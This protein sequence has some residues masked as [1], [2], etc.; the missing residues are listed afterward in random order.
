M[1]LKLP[2]QG[3]V[4]QPII[5]QQTITT[6]RDDI[7]CQFVDCEK[8]QKLPMFKPLIMETT[9]LL[10]CDSYSLQHNRQEIFGTLGHFQLVVLQSVLQVIRQTDKRLAKSLESRV[11][12]LN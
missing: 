4:Y 12:F 1:P 6:L 9:P 10:I 8:C 11:V 5:K 2:Q 3:S 7:P